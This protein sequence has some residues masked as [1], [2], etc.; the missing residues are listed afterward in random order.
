MRT[1]Q[2]SSDFPGIPGDFHSQRLPTRQHLL[3]RHRK[4]E[5]RDD[6]VEPKRMLALAGAFLINLQ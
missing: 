5:C 4:D 2:L 3:W 1:V 6:Q